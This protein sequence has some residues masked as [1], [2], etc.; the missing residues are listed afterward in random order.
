[1]KRPS[2]HFSG[3]AAS[4]AAGSGS[5]PFPVPEGYRPSPTRGRLA[6]GRGTLALL[7]PLLLGFY[8]DDWV[9]MGQI[10]GAVWTVRAELWSSILRHDP[11]VRSPVVFR[12]LTCSLFRDVPAFWHATLVAAN[13]VIVF[14]LTALARLLMPA[15]TAAPVTL[16]LPV[17]AAWMTLPWTSGIRFWPTMLNVHVY[18]IVFLALTSHLV[19]RWRS[20]QGPVLAPFA[21]Y[22]AVCLGYEAL[23]MQFLV[24][25]AIA[26]VELR[27]RSVN[28]RA[29]TRSL[30]ALVAAQACAVLW[31]QFARSALAS[32]RQIHPEWLALFWSNLRLTVPEMVGSFGPARWIAV[33]AF[34]IVILGVAAAFRQGL[35]KRSMAWADLVGVLIVLLGL[36]SGSAISAA[37]FSM[38]GRS[39]S[40]FGVEARGLAVISLWVA[41]GMAFLVGLARAHAAGFRCVCSKPGSCSPPL[42]FWPVT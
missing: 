23:Y 8:L 31:N 37:V 6:G 16:A 20:G 5:T 42:R 1:M 29:V 9:L 11:T 30:V 28:R 22:L 21:A 36:A 34:L 13:A 4:A 7:Q 33:P 39:F 19:R 27:R 12:W 18:F 25:A 26:V 15:N 40:W 32:P 3:P 41:A 17:A 14:Q 24:P 10:Y 38:G 2:A 35:K